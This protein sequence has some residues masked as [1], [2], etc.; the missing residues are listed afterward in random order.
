MPGYYVVLYCTVL[1]HNVKYCTIMTILSDRT[2]KYL[3]V[4]SRTYYTVPRGQAP[5]DDGLRLLVKRG[6]EDHP[7]IR[8][9]IL[10]LCD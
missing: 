5:P 3:T 7:A 6:V 1:Y 9:L 10:A 2:V 4:P 8:Y